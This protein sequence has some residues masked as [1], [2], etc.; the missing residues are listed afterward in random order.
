MFS[1][2][3]SM[4]WSGRR[5]GVHGFGS[6]SAGSIMTVSPTDGVS[7]ISS[8]VRGLRR[9]RKPQLGVDIGR[10]R[11]VAEQRQAEQFL[12]EPKRRVVGCL[13][14]HGDACQ[15]RVDEHRGDGL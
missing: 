3:A 2:N 1:V 12:V 14:G 9:Q 5:L 8:P 10:A 6:T 11:R 4:M 15:A 7:G 13:L